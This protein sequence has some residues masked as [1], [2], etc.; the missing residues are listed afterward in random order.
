MRV[1]RSFRE[2]SVKLREEMRRQM[3]KGGASDEWRLK[4]K[5]I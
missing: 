2:Q 3:K 4:V 5:S 1:G